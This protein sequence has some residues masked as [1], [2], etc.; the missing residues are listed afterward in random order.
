MK[1]LIYMEKL[2]ISAKIT[3]FPGAQQAPFSSGTT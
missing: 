2:K 3:Y 1:R